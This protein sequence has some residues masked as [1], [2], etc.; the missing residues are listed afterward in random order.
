MDF[1]I[2][3]PKITKDLKEKSRLE[4]LISRL[5]SI[6]KDIRSYEE[7]ISLNQANP[8]KLILKEIDEALLELEK[9]SNQL[10]LECL[11]TQEKDRCNCFI[12]IN[13]GVGGLDSND[14]VSMLLRMYLRFAQKMSFF[15]EVLSIS[16]GEVGF[17]SCA[18]KIDGMNAYGWFKG[19]VGL[20][21]LI[22]ISPFNAAQKRMTSQAS[23][24]VYPEVD[25]IVDI[26]IKEKDLKIDTYRASGAGGQHVNTTDSAVRITHIPTNLVAQC[27]SSRSQHK[28][29]ETALKILRAR[30]HDYE[31]KAKE[32]TDKLRN[33]LDLRDRQI[34]CYT[35][36][37]Y[38]MVKDLR[39]GYISYDIKGVLDGD[40]GSFIESNLINKKLD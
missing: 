16:S 39:S 35:L 18:I 14:W 29:K 40:L 12:E 32:I 37:P 34:R 15:A 28:N 1:G 2:N 20:H 19:E 31:L 8:D 30:L 6:K 17:K 7:L 23:V 38:Q 13:A 26:F 11:F 24:W 36:N 9:L 33:S 25:D 21:K 22:R 3:N 4:A 10:A 27:Q 5:D